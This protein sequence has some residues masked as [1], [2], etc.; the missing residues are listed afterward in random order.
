MRLVLRALTRAGGLLLACLPILSSAAGPSEIRVCEQ[1]RMGGRCADLRWGLSDLRQAQLDERIAS[2]E[3]RTGT[4]LMCSQPQFTGQCQTFTASIADTRRSSLR[5]AVASLR[6]V[7][8]GGGGR[9][10]G[11]GN[12]A[13]WQ[14]LALETFTEPNYQGRSKVF[15]DDA[16][17]LAE[18]GLNDQ[19]S[20]LRVIGGRWRV[21]RHADFVQCSD[22]SSDVPDLRAIG[23]DNQVSSIQELGPT[24]WGGGPRERAR[25]P[26]QLFENDNYG[27][28]SI[29]VAEAVANL[30]SLGFNDLTSSVRIAPWQRWEVCSDADFGGNCRVLDES[31]PSMRPFGLNDQISSIRPLAE[32]AREPVMLYEHANF[33]GRSIAVTDAVTDLRSLNF[34]DLA[35]SIRIPPRER[36]MICSDAEYRGRCETVEGSV[37][38]L[39]PLQL[40]DKVSSLRRVD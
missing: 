35:S 5:D 18:L 30:Q 36:W 24:G 29:S 37:A 21:C 13:G 10:G 2:F 15:T 16:R 8:E 22:V 20:S 33:G 3:I 26:A 14:R 34:N 12:A 1:P 9:W 28:R 39:V 7:R 38:N 31:T 11:Y 27:G 25:V 23:L 4:W 40:N 19:I 32:A 6:P 17:N